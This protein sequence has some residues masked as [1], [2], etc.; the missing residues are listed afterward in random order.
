MNMIR[1][2][3]LSCCLFFDACPGLAL[4]RPDYPVEITGE[5]KNFPKTAAGY[6]RSGMTMFKPDMEDYSVSYNF[7]GPLLD[8]TVTLYFYNGF[9]D[10]TSQWEVEKQ[11][12]PA[13]HP[14]AKLLSE[15]PAT[16]RKNGVTYPALV[17]TYRY[18][19]MVAAR[20]QQFFTEL[21]L[22]SHP[23]RFFKVR[24]SS[25]FAEATAAAA[26]TREL[27]EAIDWAK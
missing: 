15:R 3:L 16:F 5:L 23:L 17:A 24:S 26:K 7:F 18:E 20:Q 10:L 9:P 21:I 13:M 14:S 6:K 11:Q 8:N 4:Q 27:I 22:V 12:I 25:P 2:T 1:T 19:E